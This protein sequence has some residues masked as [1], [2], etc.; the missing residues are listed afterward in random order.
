VVDRFTLEDLVGRHGLACWRLA[1]GA[2]TV[3]LPEERALPVAREAIRRAFVG[4]RRGPDMEATR[5]GLLSRTRAEALDLLSLVAEEFVD[6]VET[7]LGEHYRRLPETWRTALWLTVVEG[8]PASA[9]AEVLGLDEENAE[10]MASQAL[11]S[12]RRAVLRRG[13]AEADECAEHSARFVAMFEGILPEASADLQAVRAH[14]SA[15]RRCRAKVLRVE[16]LEAGLRALAPLPIGGTR[17]L[18][19]EVQR[20]RRELPVRAAA[21][22]KRRRSAKVRAAPARS[23]VP[24][25]ERM[26]GPAGAVEIV[27]A[28]PAP[29]HL[30]PSG[31]GQGLADA[32]EKA[33][34]EAPAAPAGRDLRPSSRVPEL[35][36]AVEKAPAARAGRDLRRPGRVAGLAGAAAVVLGASGAVAVGL[37]SGPQGPGQG[38]APS[39]EAAGNGHHASNAGKPPPPPPVAVPSTAA[40]AAG[41]A[42]GGGAGA[43]APRNSA[44]GANATTGRSQ[45]TSGG[46]NAANSSGG[47]GSSSGG[48][49]SSSGGSGSSSG[50]SGSSSGGSGSGGGGGGVPIISVGGSVL[51]ITPPMVGSTAVP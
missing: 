15:C 29:R 11:A 12:L 38:T 6:V 40:V 31:R 20:A 28:E 25:P 13:T 21:R 42:Q 16:A 10:S 5:A 49:G 51:G 22:P 33:A 43:P 45:P 39:R 26:A 41:S 4:G 2:T 48:S 14:L 18:L 35:V 1:V 8:L 44:G 24:R 37:R 47:S 23:A 46:G 19:E 27:F 9:V 34:G 3:S 30:G 32:G 17:V 50:G 36:G 7:G